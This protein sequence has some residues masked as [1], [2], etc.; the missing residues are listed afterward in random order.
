[1]VIEPS[2]PAPASSRVGDLR[3]YDMTGRRLHMYKVRG[4]AS[5]DYGWISNR[6]VGV[7]DLAGPVRLWTTR[8]CT[9][10]LC[11]ENELPWR[12]LLYFHA[13]MRVAGYRWSGDIAAGPEWVSPGQL[14]LG[15]GVF[16][17]AFGWCLEINRGATQGWWMTAYRRGEK[18]TVAWRKDLLSPGARVAIMAYPWICAVT[19]D[20][21]RY[22]GHA[23]LL[24]IE[25]GEHFKLC[26]ARYVAVLSDVPTRRAVP[27]MRKSLP[28]SSPKDDLGMATAGRAGWRSGDRRGLRPGRASIFGGECYLVAPTNKGD[29]SSGVNP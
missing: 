29:T 25:T 2:G 8:Q 17:P 4:A 15:G 13:L 20:R 22:T 12:C 28:K 11:K 19:D 26:E 16:D 5:C 27:R 7:V 14:P 23:I 24:N 21:D 3:I 10:V 6:E 18:R 1:M 9:F